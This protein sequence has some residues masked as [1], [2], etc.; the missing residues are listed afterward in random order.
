MQQIWVQLLGGEDPLEKEMATHSSISCLG[1][2]Q[3]TLVFLAW[4]IPQTEETGGLHIAHGV[5][6]S[7]AQLSNEIT[8]NICYTGL[9]IV[10]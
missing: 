6:K 10:K 8:T 1:N 3:H 2:W 9:L 7:W 4:E 5:A